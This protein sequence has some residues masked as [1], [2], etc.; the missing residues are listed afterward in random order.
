MLTFAT[1]QETESVR[2]QNIRLDD[3]MNLY[4][5][6]LVIGCHFGSALAQ[7]DASDPNA[8]L[9]DDFASHG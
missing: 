6:A 5:A 3:L 8:T 4:R 2:Q 7:A 9:K 1:T